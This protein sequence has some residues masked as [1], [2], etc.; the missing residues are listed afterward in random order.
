MALPRVSLSS[1]FSLQHRPRS[2]G[3]N[4]TVQT[5]VS[6]KVSSTSLYPTS[7]LRRCQSSF[8]QSI[9]QSRQSSWL[10]NKPWISRILGPNN[11]QN[12]QSWLN[13]QLIIPVIYLI[14]PLS[15]DI[16]HHTRLTLILVRPLC[17]NTDIHIA[18]TATN[19]F[20]Y[21]ETRSPRWT[22][23]DVP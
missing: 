16:A 9:C 13:T 14:P 10:Q 17:D 4:Y 1:T 22:L 12:M 11:I 20:L 8:P 19:F 23:S 18:E 7:V 2:S 5:R 3:H 21:L 6:M 15:H